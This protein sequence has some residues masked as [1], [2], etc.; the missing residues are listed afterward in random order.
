MTVDDVSAVSQ[1]QPNDLVPSG[2]RVGDCPEF[3]E[4]PGYGVAS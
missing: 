4:E 2:I 1:D 3:L